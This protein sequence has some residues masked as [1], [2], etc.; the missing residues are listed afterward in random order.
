MKLLI[1]F[2]IGITA[3]EIIIF[4][5]T[6]F[7]AILLIGGGVIIYLLLFIVS[8]YFQLKNKNSH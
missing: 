8:I 3:L 2:I 7:P 1:V 4:L 5:A 6:H